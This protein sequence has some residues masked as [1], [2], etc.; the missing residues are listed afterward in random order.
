MTLK[1]WIMFPVMENKPRANPKE[2]G[3][4]NLF[5][6]RESVEGIPTRIREEKCGKERNGTMTVC[7]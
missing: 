3:N 4:I 5:I 7:P 2:K 1:E 6:I